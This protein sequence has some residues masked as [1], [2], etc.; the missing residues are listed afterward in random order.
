MR[1][2]SGKNST[3]SRFAETATAEGKIAL[4]PVVEELILSRRK[5]GITRERIVAAVEEVALRKKWM[6]EVAPTARPRAHTGVR[7]LSPL[8]FGEG[9]ALPE[10]E[11]RTARA[12]GVPGLRAVEPVGSTHV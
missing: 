2:S 1:P 4:P 11:V 6:R 9:Y 5:K 7:H 8:A 3:G 10:P 12:T